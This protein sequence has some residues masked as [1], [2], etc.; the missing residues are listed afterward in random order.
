MRRSGER[1]RAGHEYGVWCTIEDDDAS[2]SYETSAFGCAGV[3]EGAARI[4]AGRTATAVLEG[5]A[6][7][8]IFNCT[9]QWGK[10]TVA[11]IRAIHRGDRGEKLLEVFFDSPSRTMVWES[12][13]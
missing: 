8:G 2:Y 1:G 5:S 10:S 6:K 7:R 12:M 4:R 3:Y 13:P 9:R 11:G